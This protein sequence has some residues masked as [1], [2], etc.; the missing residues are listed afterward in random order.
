[1]L[2]NMSGSSSSLLPFRRRV[3]FA[4]PLLAAM[5]GILASDQRPE[6]WPAWAA[7]FLCVVPALLKS[8]STWLGCLLTFLIFGFWH[9]NHV[10]TDTGYQRSRQQSYDTE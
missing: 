9:G 7:A 6:W 2:R 10:A 1:M 4:G 5:G 8:P 3:P